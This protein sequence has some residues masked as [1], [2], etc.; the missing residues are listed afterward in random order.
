MLSAEEYFAITGE[1][2]P[3][4]FDVCLAQ[5]EEMLHAATLYAYIGRDT[6]VMPK[7]IRDRWNRAL[8]LQTQALS[9]NG[10]MI[11]LHDGEMNSV[12][13]GK[14]SYT[15]NNSGNAEGT[16]NGALSP[17]VSHLMPLLVAYGRGLRDKCARCL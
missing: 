11:G 12:S 4:D 7:C 1:E 9:V 3:Q 16:S 10:G 17:A 5:A 6:A 2:A 15:V 8:A 14:F 13:L